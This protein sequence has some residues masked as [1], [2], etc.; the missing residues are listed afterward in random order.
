MEPQSTFQLP[1]AFDYGATFLWALTG[2]LVAARLRFDGAGV[3]ALALVTAAGGGVLRDG[4]FLQIGPPLILRTPAYIA[5]VAVAAGLVLVAGRHV[6]R[7]RPFDAVVSLVDGAAIA[8]YGLVG[9]QMARAA[10][11]GIPA[12]VFVGTV[13]AVGGGV[14]RDLLVG[15]TPEIFKPGVPTALAAIGGCLL[16][17]AL[18]SLLGLGEPVAGA[19]AIGGVFALRAVAIRFDLRT[20]PARGFDGADSPPTR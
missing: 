16:F 7:L 20:R 2:A 17:L 1:L 3:A 15:R 18:T 10:G 6:A 14:L 11:L 13:N 4:L 8:A 9:M 19:V 12:A 5:I